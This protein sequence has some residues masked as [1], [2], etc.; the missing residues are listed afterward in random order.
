M[1]ADVDLDTENNSLARV[2]I[3][4]TSKI[5]SMDGLPSNGRISQ[6]QRVISRVSLLTVTIH[7]GPHILDKIIDD[8]K[9][10]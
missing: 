6:S 3:P 7:D 1:I 5:R 10:L 2:N 8:I 9:N 4:R